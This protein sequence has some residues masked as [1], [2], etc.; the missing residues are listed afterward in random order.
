MTFTLFCF[1]VLVFNI[2]YF[3]FFDLTTDWADLWSKNYFWREITNTQRKNAPLSILV[4]KT[5]S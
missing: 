4:K 1:K 5:G 3:Y 2:L